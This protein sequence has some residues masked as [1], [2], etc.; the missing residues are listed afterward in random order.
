MSV[1]AGSAALARL[2]VVVRSLRH[3]REVGLGC[4][5]VAPGVRMPHGHWDCGMTYR[6]G[7]CWSI[8]GGR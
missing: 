5:R 3:A 7:I 8:L 6:S 2:L 1:L 4:P